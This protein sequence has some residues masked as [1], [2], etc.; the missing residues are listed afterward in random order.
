MTDGPDTGRARARTEACLDVV[1]RLDPELR[2]MITVTA[3][4]ARAAA[5]GVDAMRAAGDWAGPLAGMTVVVKDN[6]DT[7]GVRTTC[8]SPFFADHVPNADA[9]VIARLR[10]AGAVVLGKANLQELA[11][12]VRSSNPIAG[13]WRTRGTG[14]GSR[15]AP[16]A[17]RRSP[18][19]SAWPTARSAATPVDRCGSRQRCAA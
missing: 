2:A 7:A 6:I 14:P 13:R 11:F 4:A 12:G 1:E 9:P 8:G 3:D 19:R 10:Q 5:D 18:S 16:A 15:A 17:A